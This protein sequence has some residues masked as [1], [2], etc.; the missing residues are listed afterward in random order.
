MAQI[1]TKFIANNAVTNAKAS[2]MATLT[3]KGNNTGSTANALDLTVAQVNAILPVFTSSLNGLTPSSAG[4]TTNFLRADGTWAAPTG[5]GVSSMNPFGNAPNANGATITGTTLTLEPASGSFPGGVS[6]I[7]QSFA[8]N[9][10]FL[11]TVSSPGASTGSLSEG[12]GAGVSLTGTEGIAIGNSATDGGFS[13]TSAVGYGTTIGGD[14][15]IALGSFVSTTGANQFVAGSTTAII[16]N[17][18]LGSGVTAATPISTTINATGGSGTNVTGANLTL[19]GGKST[20]TGAGGEVR[21]ATSPT[22]S[23]GASTNALVIAGYFDSSQNLNLNSSL[24]LN[25]STSGTLTITPAATTTSYSITMPAA[26]ATGT[27]VLQNNGSGV[28]S[29]ASASGG[30][31]TS[32]ALADG[33]ST[34]IY[35]ISGSPVTSSG[36]LTFTLDTQTA[37]TVFAGPTTGSAAQPTFRGLV[38]ADIPNNAANTTGTASNITATSNSTLTTLSALSLPGSQVTGNISGDAANV[39]GTVAIA[40]GGTGQTT[41]NAA[42]D[43][44]S[45]MTTA[46]DLIYEDATPTAARLG[47]GTT[48]Q[49]LTVSGGLPVWSSPAT[50]GTVTSVS[51]VS[52]NGFAGTVATATTTPAITI[53]TTINSPVLAGNGTAISAATTTGT[54]STVVL[55]ASPTLTG[56][57]TAAAVSLSG[58]LNM[59]S[60]LINNVTNPVSAQDAATKSYVDAAIAGLTWKGPVQAYA[61]SNVP[62]TGSTPL[63]IDGYTVQDGDLLLL[64][65]QTTASQDGEYSAAITGGTYVLTANGLPDAIG[66]AWLVLNGTVYADSAFV[67]TSA[68]PTATFVEFAGPTA[69]TFTAPLQLSGNTVSIT[70]ST[71]ST[72]GYLSSTDWNTFNNKQPAGNYLTALT[73]DGTASGP[74]SAALTLATV[75]SNVGSF[76]NASITVNA[77]GLITAASSGSSTVT[78]IGTFNS[79][80]SSANGL[81]ISGN[82]LYAQAATTTNPG[83]VIV[84]ASGGLAL[85]TASLSINTDS[86]TTKINGSNALESIQPNEEQITLSSTDITNQY[87]DLAHTIFGS[88]ASVNSAGVYVVGGPEQQKTVDYTVSL[89][90]GSGGVTRISFSGDLATGGNAALVS[91]DILVVDYMYLA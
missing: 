43:A 70:Q 57:L 15:S 87:V 54:G 19:A 46:G 53:E 58:A 77:K 10:T 68:V 4:G 83:M 67:A 38:S 64:A 30:S 11:G 90:G 76:T 81:V 66:D 27:Q 47:I 52:A 16:S 82:D 74:G 69:Y 41:A 73:G 42:F 79:Q 88:S 59:N 13:G 48:G 55:S 12:F 33:S 85:S 25:G 62:L 40:N 44:L 31:V 5:T 49:V 51:V 65:G 35:S 75:N 22:G 36:T 28:L 84:P 2:Q 32:V 23:S 39:T 86:S 6:T 61:T 24:N 50:S 89:T 45:P 56:T 7:V 18:Y 14:H 80:A 29:W 91:G 37:N 26:Q 34:P 3:I 71:T 72:N 60:N 63:V 9:K 8:G 20:G 17:T 21:F 78:T 1:Q